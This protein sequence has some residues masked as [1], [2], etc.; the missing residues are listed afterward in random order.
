MIIFHPTSIL[1]HSMGDLDVT[2]YSCVENR[3]SG[4]WYIEATFPI[5]S[6]IVKD[7]II[8]VPTKDSNKQPFRVEEITSTDV[9]EVKAYHIGFDLKRYGVEL[10]T[11]IS[12]NCQTALN[13]L[14]A[15]AYDTVP[16][17]FNTDVVGNQTFSIIDTDVY[18]G[19]L[20]IADRY[21]G[22]VV[23]DWMTVSIKSSIGSDRGMVLE[24]GKN[25]RE[26]EV[27]E[28]WSLV[29]TKLKPIG[30]EGITLTPEWLIA[31]IQYSKPYTKIMQFDSDE[32]SNLGLVAQLYL[33]RF[34]IPRVNYKVK[35]N[36]SF[37]A[38]GFPYLSLFTYEELESFTFEELENLNE[39]SYFEL[40]DIILV[41]ARQFQVLT[42]VIQYRYNVMSGYVE[43][44]E[45]GNYRPTVKSAVAERFDPIIENLGKTQLRIDESNQEI[46]LLAS[47]VTG[48]QNDL[49]GLDTRLDTAE[50]KI[51][52]T[53]ITST[54]RAS[55][56]YTSDLNAKENS[57]FKQTTAPTHLNGRFWLDTSV[58]P[59]VLYRSNGTTWVKATPTQASEVG[60]YSSSDGANLA[61]RVS[62]AESS[63]VIQAGQIATKVEQSTFD[64]LSGRVNTAESTITQQAGQIALKADQTT[65]NAVSAVANSKAKTFLS[66]P[67]TP[68]YVG[69][70]WIDTNATTGANRVCTTQRLTGAYVASDWTKEGVT[71]R[72]DS[73][74]LKI[75][76]TAITSTVRSST[77]YSTDLGGKVN[78]SELANY[79]TITQ[80]STAIS[81]EIGS[82]RIG[83]SNLIPNSS[84]T[85]GVART[86]WDIWNT[87]TLSYSN[88]ITK[89]QYLSSG[90]FGIQTPTFSIQSGEMYTVS[91]DGASEF[92]TPSLNYNFL[93]VNGV[94]VQTLPSVTV[95]A[96][97]TN[98]RR[99]SFT[100]TSN[101]TSSN[102][103]I[104]IGRSGG[105]SSSDGFKIGRVKV[106]I[107]TKATGWGLQV[108]EMR[109]AKYIFDGIKAKFYSD[110]QEWYDNNG[111]LKVSFDTVNNRFKFEGEIIATTG[112][113]TGSVTS[114]SGSIAGWSIT[115]NAIAKGNVSLRSDLERIY[116]GTAYLYTFGTGVMA[117]SGSFRVGGT[118]TASGSTASITGQLDVQGGLRVKFGTIEYAITRD[119][120]GFLR[121]L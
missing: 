13:E 80:T 42:E 99:Y 61:G 98:L 66:T 86:G 3:E 10:S 2:A 69:D 114:T 18:S 55:S 50:Q 104:L 44:V 23:F 107:G 34:K 17:T 53:A 75:T 16:F 74:E 105:T 36:P 48:V 103:R 24:Y 37:M 117:T 106:E 6:P 93:I 7:T 79:S 49:G 9:I 83:V 120:N 43:S 40:G 4:D 52:P 89:V 60:A 71:S 56:E 96:S 5:D 64:T 35:G 97:D 54:V 110:G 70:I 78:T 14:K 26:N 22:H 1:D 15:Q 51:T 67:T 112:S 58:T 81:L 101:T 63:L 39:Q 45:F 82:L 47:D 84:L 25:I 65:V 32:V 100:F 85:D 57:I 59:N 113:F 111:N 87:A 77:E 118:F 21:N 92:N 30:N 116:F 91:F 27:N 72:L 46:S 31:D 38:S 95:N 73:A 94:G 68:Y 33:D 115:S 90:N 62:T 29:V 8:V 108:N 41:R 121:A 20:D 88:G 11:V 102:A 12:A 109:T 19:L 119:S 28:D 76:P